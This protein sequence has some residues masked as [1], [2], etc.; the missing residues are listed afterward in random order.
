VT[1][2]D[3]GRVSS[4]RE[5]RNKGHTVV[6][7]ERVAAATHYVIA[8][9]DPARLG[10]TKLHKILW[11]ADLANFRRQGASITGLQQYSRAPVGP[12]S[13][14]ISRA[15]GWLVRCRHV[16]ERSVEIAG[17]PRR[18]FVT[19]E[20]PDTSSL[21]ERQ[22]S[23]LR[24]M[25][26]VIAPLTARQLTEVTYADPLWQQT[27]PDQPMLVSTGSVITPS[28]AATYLMPRVRDSAA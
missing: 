14:Y 26:N 4:V 22:T 11:Y 13:P 15:V 9:A 20:Q 8:Q 17:F 1:S 2:V 3:V 21:A 25:I 16:A 7:V 12:L 23:I 6:D 28:P 5:S 18:Q 19:L 24:Q 10:H 27:E